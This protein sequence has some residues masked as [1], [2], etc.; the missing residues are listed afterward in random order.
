MKDEQGRKERRIS[1]QR[2]QDT[3]KKKEERQPQRHRGHGAE[4]RREAIYSQM[5]KTYA[6]KQE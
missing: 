5:T 2:H 6:D 3:K 4:G 1:P